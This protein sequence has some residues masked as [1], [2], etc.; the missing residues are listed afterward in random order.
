MLP[1]A[2]RSSAGKDADVAALTSR[3]L[4]HWPNSIPVVDLAEWRNHT[5]PA[6][7]E[8]PHR[9]IEMLLAEL[10]VAGQVGLRTTPVNA[11]ATP[12]EFPAAFAAARWIS[13][14]QEVVPTLYHEPVRLNDAAVRKLVGLLDGTRTR[15]DLIA[16]MGD[17]FS[18]PDGRAH[19]DSLLTKL[20]K[21]A[22]LVG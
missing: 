20:A 14:E 10:Y 7:A 4:A 12:G 16:A 18:R 1:L 9:P 3:L 2:P 17:T 6:N 15:D 22:L 19:L 5:L 11:V 8:Q 13:R 21:E